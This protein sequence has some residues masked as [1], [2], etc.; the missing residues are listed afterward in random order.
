MAA[1]VEIY[2]WSFDA[3]FVSALKPCWSKR[4]LTLPNTVLM[5]M[6]QHEPKWLNGHRDD[7]LYH[8]FLSMTDILVV[9]M[10][11]H[12]LDAQGKLDPLLK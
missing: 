5:A 7:V 8:K 3:L 1:N 11:C 10:I 4:A 2:T 12:D 9:V 6:R